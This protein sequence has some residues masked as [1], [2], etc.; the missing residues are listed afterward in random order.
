VNHAGV[1]TGSSGSRRTLLWWLLNAIGFVVIAAIVHAMT[2]GYDGI[3]DRSGHLLGRDFI[4]YWTAGQ[5][6]ARGELHLL[7]D[8]RQYS[9]LQ[10][11]LF[12]REISPHNWSYPP[13]MLLLTIPF[14]WLDYLPSLVLWSAVTFSAY[15]AAARLA[16]L[17]GTWLLLLALSPASLFDLWNGQNGHLSAALLVAG[18]ALLG[19]RDILAG[20]CFGLLCYKPHL[21][22]LIPFVVA[23]FGAWRC[24]A[25]AAVTVAVAAGLSAAVFG[26]AVW[27]DWL[28]GIAPYQ[29]ALLEQGTGVFQLMMPTSFMAARLLGASVTASWIFAGI[30]S[31]A[32]IGTATWAV[33]R[34]RGQ[35]LTRAAADARMALLLTAAMLATPYGFNYDM[36]IT[37]IAVALVA[38]HA[39]SVPTLRMAGL[40]G[41]AVWVLPAM[42]MP[43]NML[44]MTAGPVVLGLFLLTLA[45]A[46]GATS[47]APAP[48]ILGGAGA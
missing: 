5:A 31:C 13:P 7:A 22:L 3:F 35:V 27:A 42:I 33:I 14:A 43:L 32:A 12:G 20:V 40:A 41:M 11:L 38:R 17:G 28:T 37:S 34:T 45:R 46:L 9:Q 26:I 39:G 6:W 48:A 30:V 24:F 2:L 23:A 10:Q 44:Y 47:N 15:L 25:A 36:T 8:P 18:F 16:G 4:N 29:R 19:R 21:G 1:Q